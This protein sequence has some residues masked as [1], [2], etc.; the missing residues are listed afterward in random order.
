MQTT[1]KSNGHATDSSASSEWIV[2]CGTSSQLFRVLPGTLSLD[3][4]N[5]V[6]C[7]TARGLEIG[8][9]LA[10]CQYTSEESSDLAQATIVRLSRPEDQLLWTQ[11][12]KLSEDASL[13]C[14]SFLQSNG[15]DDV[16][17]EVEPLFDGRTLFFHFL[18]EPG[19]V[20]EAYVEELATVYQK[21]V[22]SSK[23]AELLEHGCGPG[24]GTP[25]K[26]GC[27][28]SGGCAVCS[29]TGACGSKKK[30]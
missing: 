25:E 16:L 13:A 23:F 2:R 10:E 28:T 15:L 1:V 22:A 5:T 17:I 20:T 19:E 30:K 27:G 6:L 18:G 3:R 29:I 4:G 21:N 11:L 8:E 14:Q 24:C 9:V 12:R 7:R 26:S